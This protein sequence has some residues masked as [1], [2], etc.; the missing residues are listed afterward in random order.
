MTADSPPLAD[1]IMTPHQAAEA[2]YSFPRH[3]LKTIMKSPSK[4]PLCLI[5]CGSFSPI[6][7]LHLRMFEMAADYVR[8]NTDFELI[9]GYLSPVSDA[10]KKVGLARAHHRYVAGIE[11]KGQ[12]VGVLTLLVSLVFGCASLP[13]TRHQRGSWWT[14]GK[15]RKKSISPRR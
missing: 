6:T 14:L 15:R 9:G 7:Y 2:E 12:V 3:R 8:F 10:Y 13:S 1:G 4:T 5:A 11:V